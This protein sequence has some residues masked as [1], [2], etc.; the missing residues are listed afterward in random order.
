MTERDDA[1]RKRVPVLARLP[2]GRDRKKEEPVSLSLGTKPAD[3]PDEKC[4]ACEPPV[5]FDGV[6]SMCSRP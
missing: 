5:R 6:P 1:L 2:R 4:K 3:R